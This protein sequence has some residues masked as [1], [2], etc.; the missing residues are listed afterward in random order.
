[1]NA[2]VVIQIVSLITI[3][4]GALSIIIRAEVVDAEGQ[5]EH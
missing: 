4:A 3:G 2:C 1:L 5:S